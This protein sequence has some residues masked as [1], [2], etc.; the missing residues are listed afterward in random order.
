MNIF[1][2]CIYLH[3]S[4]QCDLDEIKRLKRLAME[5]P[6]TDP[7]REFIGGG[8]KAESRHE[9]LLIKADELGTYLLDKIEEKLEYEERI[10]RLIE[11][12]DDPPGALV[13][14]KRYIQGM[15]I[16]DIAK[17]LGLSERRVQDIKANAIKQ[18][19]KLHSISCDS[20]V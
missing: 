2:R 17:D 10:Y 11:E 14:R 7:S 15:P 9:R 18:C 8:F 19:E 1:D 20:A 3:K 4:I 5:I 13:L 12:L 6:A 16:K